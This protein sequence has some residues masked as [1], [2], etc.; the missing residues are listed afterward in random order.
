MRLL[1]AF[2]LV[3]GLAGLAYLAGRARGNRM[4]TVAGGRM[5]A[6]HSRPVYHGAYVAVLALAP[7]LLVLAGTAEEDTNLAS[8]GTVPTALALTLAAALREGGATNL[9]ALLVCIA[10]L[11][12]GESPEP[13][14]LRLAADPLPH[15]WQADPGPRVGLIFYRALL[16]AGDLALVEAC[17][18][19][20]RAQGLAPRALWVSSLRD[21]AVQRGVGD[22]LEREAAEAVLCGSNCLAAC[23]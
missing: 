19:E 16:Q 8:L 22:L 12:R 9:E 1:I 13:P 5:G 23:R 15:D 2:A 21:P 18:Q 11:L 7:A 17:L 14:V 3:L 6:V 4:V 20:L 10:G